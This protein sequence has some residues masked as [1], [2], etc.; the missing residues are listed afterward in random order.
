MSIFRCFHNIQFHDAQRS[1]TARQHAAAEAQ[2]C[3]TIAHKAIGLVIELEMGFVDLLDKSESASYSDNNNKVKL[4]V[5]RLSH[6]QDPLMLFAR[7]AQDETMAENVPLS[8]VTEL[9]LNR[10]RENPSITNLFYT[11]RSAGREDRDA[12]FEL[13]INQQ[14]SDVE[15]YKPDLTLSGDLRRHQLCCRAG[16][17]ALSGLVE[18]KDSVSHSFARQSSAKLIN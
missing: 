7:L 12:T 18:F 11:R 6:R 2:Q 15:L 8:V 9:N 10:S 4:S 17:A 13:I 5:C 14:N 1:E 16:Y 3:Q